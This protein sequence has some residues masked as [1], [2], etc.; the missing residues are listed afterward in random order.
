MFDNVFTDNIEYKNE[1]KDFY[2]TGYLSTS[3]LDTV[4][5][6]FTEN[7][8][9]NISDQLNN[10]EVRAFSPQSVK[11]NL[12]H[13]HLIKD[14]RLIPRAKI[15]ESGIDAKGVWIKTKLNK[16]I[17]GYQE[18]KGS[19]E[20]GFVDA[21]SIEFK[22]EDFAYE[23]IGG[24]KVRVVDKVSVGGVAYTGR[25][26]NPDCLI[27]DFGMKSIN[28]LE[29]QTEES[30]M[31]DETPVET[32]KEVAKETPAA[33]VAATPATEPVAPAP[34]ETPAPATPAPAE[35]ATPAEPTPAEAPVAKETGE[36]GKAKMLEEIKSFISDEIKKLQ[37]EQKN[38]VEA[39]SNKFKEKVKNEKFK[40]MNAFLESKGFTK[41]E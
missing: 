36:E 22:A 4:N 10:K 41:E 20:E 19:I 30:K 28:A 11:V 17:D 37:P 40:F 2:V 24:K 5:D 8:L 25:P 27:T 16:F 9:K 1:G 29:A 12:E 15:I 39:K 26:V 13:E 23:T 6:I 7:C 34:V 18:L 32:P 33:P 14:R 31:T 3:K 35:A 21:F 38:I